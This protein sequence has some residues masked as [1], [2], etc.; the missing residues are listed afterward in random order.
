MSKE[1]RIEEVVSEIWTEWA[2]V[3]GYSKTSFLSAAKPV[4]SKAP[5]F[6]HPAP[7]PIT[8]ER[9]EAALK[10]LG[11]LTSALE[12]NLAHDL[13][14]LLSQ[15]EKWRECS[16][17][18]LPKAH[19]DVHFCVRGISGVFAGVFG[20]NETDDEPWVGVYPNGCSDNCGSWDN[21]EITHWLPRHVPAPPTAE[22]SEMVKALKS[23]K[24]THRSECASAFNDGISKAIAI[25]R[26]FE[27]KGK[28]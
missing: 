5:E 20:N 22:E 10:Q 1:E 18:S 11:Y 9:I 17:T 28:K 2:G 15:P 26:E 8:K 24:D 3:A 7:P 16:D 6:N 12:S 19:S 23:A 14:P 27:Q 25:V 4:L 21:W 13:A